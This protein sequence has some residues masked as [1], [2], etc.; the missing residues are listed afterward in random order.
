MSSTLV[1]IALMISLS[2]AVVFPELQYSKVSKSIS[3]EYQYMVDKQRRGFIT[4]GLIAMSSFFIALQSLSVPIFI[5]HLIIDVVF[6]IYA[7]TAF[8]VR[9]SSLQRNSLSYVDELLADDD[10]VEYLKQAV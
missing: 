1:L 5:F 4:L 8:Q 2:V 10:N 3:N 6:G 9:S 7:Y